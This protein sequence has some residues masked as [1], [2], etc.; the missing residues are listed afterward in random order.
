[1]IPRGMGSMVPIQ[2]MLKVLGSMKKKSGE[3]GEDGRSR[4]KMFSKRDIRDT[5][6][7]ESTIFGSKKRGEGFGKNR[8][9]EQRKILL[10][11]KRA[12]QR[13]KEGGW[14]ILIPGDPV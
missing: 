4:M 13:R 2:S 14:K 8:G 12:P 9:S 5:Q 6:L 3:G 10:Y 1:M 11:M 7:W